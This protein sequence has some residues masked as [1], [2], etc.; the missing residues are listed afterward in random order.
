M[1]SKEEETSIKNTIQNIKRNQPVQVNE[2]LN[3][4]NIGKPQQ[5]SKHHKRDWQI[6]KLVA[7]ARLQSKRYPQHPRL[8]GVLSN[9]PKD[10]TKEELDWHWRSY[11]HFLRPKH[12]DLGKHFKQFHKAEKEVGHTIFLPDYESELIGY[13]QKLGRKQK[14][15]T[16]CYYDNNTRT[17][18]QGSKSE[19]DFI[20]Y[21]YFELFERGY[22]IE[23]TNWLLGL[24]KAWNIHSAIIVEAPIPKQHFIDLFLPPKKKRG[25]TSG[26]NNNDWH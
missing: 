20:E 15:I 23:S 5:P 14:L 24:P 4:C 11:Y 10:L 21:L 7:F 1:L 8:H 13:I 3:Y 6:A 26:R 12:Q 2:P 22:P 16:R 17:K 18:R 9:P 25:Q 19:R